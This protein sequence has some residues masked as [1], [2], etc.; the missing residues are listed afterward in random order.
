MPPRCA[1]AK[2]AGPWSIE[3]RGVVPNCFVL[4]RS[5]RLF[6]RMSPSRVRYLVNSF[7]TTPV[8]GS[9]PTLALLLE[10]GKP[11]FASRFMWKSVRTAAK[12]TVRVQI[13]VHRFKV[14]RSCTNR[15]SQLQRCICRDNYENFTF[16]AAKMGRQ[17]CSGNINFASTKLPPS[18]NPF[19]LPVSS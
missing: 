16:E 6:S 3:F 8:S 2:I 1:C 9:I 11:F 13:G 17:F 12:C 14:H 10:V 7:I 18:P 4:S 19:P 15:C 5:A